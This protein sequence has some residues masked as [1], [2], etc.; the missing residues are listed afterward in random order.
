MYWQ[1]F[2]ARSFEENAEYLRQIEQYVENIHVFNW[3]A[4]GRYPLGDAIE[5][6]KKYTAILSRPRT[7]LL[8]FMP[9][10]ELATLPREA[11]ALK[12]IIL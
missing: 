11:E 8:E 4:N 10:D 6:W 12:K 9:D 7:M 2:R 1:P 5:E 3:D